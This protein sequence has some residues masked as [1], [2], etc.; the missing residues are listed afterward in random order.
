M[1]KR[2]LAIVLSVAISGCVTAYKGPPPNFNLKGEAALAEYDRFKFYEGIWWQPANAF[3]MGTNPVGIHWAGSLEPVMSEVSPKALQIEQDSRVYLNA[4]WISYVA[5][6]GSIIYELS[7]D[8][9]KMSIEQ[10]VLMYGS[11]GIALGSI[12]IR[13][14]HM[15]QAAQQYNQDLRTKFTPAISWNYEF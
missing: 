6:V 3:R 1:T 10:T 4:Y 15:R 5:F 14:H 12:G 9:N 2:I 8:D 13:A 11:L 7:D